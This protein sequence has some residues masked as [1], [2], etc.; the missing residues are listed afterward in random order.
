MR[1]LKIPRGSDPLL[2]HSPKPPLLGLT[3]RALVWLASIL[4]AEAQGT[5]Q[6]LDF[7]SPNANNLTSGFVAF[8][9]AFPGWSGW[10]G[11]TNQA[12]LAGY[13]F[14]SGGLALVTL[15]TPNSPQGDGTLAIG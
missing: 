8:S 13:N 5:F 6:N 7:E 15:I 1:I 3:V 2:K 14:I 4:C 9:D 10:I 12:S 11:G